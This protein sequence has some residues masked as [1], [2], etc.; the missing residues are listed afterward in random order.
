MQE[1]NDQS[2]ENERGDDTEKVK[3]FKRLGIIFVILFTLILLSILIVSIVVLTGVLKNEDTTSNDL[4]DMFLNDEIEAI[5]LLHDGQTFKISDLNIGDEDNY[6]SYKI[7]ARVDLD[8][9]GKDEQIIDGLYGGMYLDAIDG[10][11]VVFAEGDGTGRVLGCIVNDGVW[12]EYSNCT[13]DGY[14]YVE[15]EKYY[16]SSYLAQSVSFY[17][18]YPSASNGFTHEMYCIDDEEVT[19]KKFDAMYEKY[20]GE[21]NISNYYIDEFI[22]IV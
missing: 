9:D 20:T 14:W 17:M 4:L 12:I 11:V 19:R 21:A 5:D 13:H 6:M 7:G 3:L 10:K 22:T 8:N 15:L 1:L 18:E 16:G 2:D